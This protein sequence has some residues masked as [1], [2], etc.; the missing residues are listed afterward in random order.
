MKLS[1]RELI[2]SDIENIVDY[3]LNADIDFLRHM[4]ADKQKLPERNTWINLIKAEYGKAYEEKEFYYIVWL[5][6]EQPV[7]H[8]NINN[9]Q[10][11]K[12]ATMHLHLWENGSRRKGLAIEF[13]KSSIKYY[14]K[15]FR[16]QKLICEI[17][18]ENIAPLKV[19][20]KNGFVLKRTYDTTP[21]WI[22]FH[23]TV[24]RYELAKEKLKSQHV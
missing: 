9:I 5:I 20:K 17:R 7:G 22:N 10:F 16:L 18:V 12:S 4:G 15:N 8:S 14:F 19:L 24:N 6:D 21:G 23:Q 13:L 11:G 3:F 1:T 2:E